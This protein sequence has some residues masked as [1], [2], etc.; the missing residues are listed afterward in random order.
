MLI[1]DIKEYIPP[2]DDCVVAEYSPAFDAIDAVAQNEIPMDG[3]GDAQSGKNC[4]RWKLL[5]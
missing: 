2:L 1:E 5:A 3:T 4:W